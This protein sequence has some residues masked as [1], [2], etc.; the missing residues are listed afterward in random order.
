MSPDSP[1]PPSPA[2]REEALFTLAQAKAGAD[3]AA[4]LDRECAG[5]PALR[6]RVE[7]LLSAH[8]A[9]EPLLDRIGGARR[10]AVLLPRA[11]DDEAVGQTLGRYKLL[12]K[13][14][15]GGCGVVYVAEQTEPVR[16]RVALKVIKLGMDTKSVVARFEA[17]RQALALMDHPNIAKVFDAGMT[18]QGRPYFVMELVR[19]IRITNYCDQ[20]QLPTQER[21]DLFIEVCQA[22]QHAHQKGI[23]H[24][25]LK[26]SNILVTVNDGVP[27]PKVID[28]GIA[29]ATEGRLTDA[30]VYTQLHQFIGTPAYMS[31]E[32]A[33]MTSLDIDTR[34]DIY[35][36][37]VLLYELLMGKTPFDPRELMAQG[38]DAM[39]RTIR[40]VE[41]ARPSTKLAALK[42]E[43]LT[44]TA[45][46]RS[47]DVPRLIQQLRG[48]LDWIVMKCLEKDRTR[49]YETANG[50]AADLQRHLD[51]EP[52]VARP[53]TAAY[54]FQKAWRRNRLAYLAAMTVGL[55]IITAVIVSSV[56][57]VRARR[58]EALARSRLAEVEQARQDAEQ[59]AQFLQQVFESPDPE[60]DGRTATVAESLDRA[61]ERLES[62]LADQP[63]RRARLQAVLAKT[64]TALGL[65]APALRLWKQVRAYRLNAAGPDDPGTLEAAT[66]L[67]QSL[68]SNGQFQA[69]LP[70]T[71]DALV[72]T[73]QRYGPE[74]TNTLALI[75]DQATVLDA[76]GR[77]AEALRLREEN[78]AAWRKVLGLDHRETVWAMENL[79]VSYYS[80]GLYE[81][82]R[83]LQEEVVALSRKVLGP[84]HP[85]TLR[86]LG[87]L[88]VDYK[89]AGRTVEAI[90]HLEDTLEKQRRVLGPEH[91]FTI[92]T[93]QTLS[94][95]YFDLG[96]RPEALQLREQVLA[97]FR[98]ALGPEHSDTIWPML[99]LAESQA[100]DGRGEEALKLVQEALALSH[101]IHGAE[102]AQTLSC[103]VRLAHLHHG[104][105]RFDA[106]AEVGE[107]MLEVSREVF[108]PESAPTLHH[109][110]QLAIYYRSAGRH[111]QAIR[112]RREIAGLRRQANG[113][114]HASTVA[115]IKELADEHAAQGE[116]KQARRELLPLAELQPIPDSAH[117]ELIC[118]AVL[119]VHQGER[120]AYESHRRLLLDRFRGTE[121]AA[122]A[123]RVAKAALLLPLPGEGLNDALALAELAITRT[124]ESPG[125]LHWRL[126][127]AA[128]ARYR[129][130]HWDG[131]EEAAA[132]A[133]TL[134]R[135]APHPVNEAA[136]SL[137]LAL[138]RHRLG[139]TDAARRALDEGAGLV[140]EHWPEPD[141]GL[142]D[143]WHDILI[144]HLLLR[145]ARA[146]I[147]GWPPETPP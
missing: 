18:E 118:L 110:R 51:H 4:F 5:D 94:G 124:N 19:G 85:V 111:D 91:P 70:V 30:T 46:R 62:D 97:L 71:E 133:V 7:V 44:T 55:A 2:A 61:A 77:H 93:M 78:L 128:L 14:G 100:A 143:S 21:L 39:R 23:I 84:E 119:D 28:F 25:D 29:K 69:A 79:E 104:A 36:L 34:S 105:R 120:D 47:A 68:F 125:L 65:H 56:Q 10:P 144:T 74:H 87:N 114:D 86:R 139:E 137:V 113:P 132:R 17:E 130:G 136:S 3:R 16:R 6:A 112:L 1:A 76:L 24:R 67:A 116:W 117:F 134:A 12:E 115:A 72:R 140:A 123:N 101:R 54:R 27:V 37:G 138:A 129:A 26:P 32:Q 98:K 141:R 31:P 107:R 43:E 20:N 106:A 15:E 49:R 88:G 83:P 13:V 22:V 109:A 82:S 95:C 38:L 122:I 11:G 48:D 92:H 45:K 66:F 58:A 59:V 135:E 8:E 73:R 80:L 60:R 57:A 9:P 121:S 41:P 127:A 108:G 42:G 147:E 145:E 102:H 33:A 146:I 53:P 103:L 52:V 63:E 96:R 142:G 81:Q 126:N 40:E 89:V 75:R 64:Y 35:S 131:A 90:Q 50:L 99:V